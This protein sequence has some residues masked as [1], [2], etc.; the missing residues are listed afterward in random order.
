M[1]YTYSPRPVTMA[2][3]ERQKA[4]R[5]E[6]ALAWNGDSRI[7]VFSDEKIFD[8]NDMR[9]KMWVAPGEKATPRQKMHWAPKCHVW[10]AIG[11]G[12]RYLAILP[13]T[14][15]LRAKRILKPCVRLLSP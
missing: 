12:W 8:T 9:K 2:L 4:K 13:M 3:T 7:I 1:K 6:F 14:A 11:V 15:Q 10:G 5:V